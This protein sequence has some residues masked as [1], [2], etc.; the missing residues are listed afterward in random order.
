MHES[1]KQAKIFLKHF[2]YIVNV[3]NNIFG[4]LIPGE[5]KSCNINVGESQKARQS[6]I[7]CAALRIKLS[8]LPGSLKAQK[9]SR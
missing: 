6:G 8:S 9:D 4:D 3:I 7:L 5:S 1:T 2:Y